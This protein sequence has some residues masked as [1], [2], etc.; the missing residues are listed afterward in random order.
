MESWISFSL[1]AIAAVIHFLFFIFE[2]FV[3]QKP[4]AEKLLK[5]T[6]EQHKAV[7]PWAFNQGFY[8]LMLS[9]GTFLGLYFVLSKKVMMAGLITS[10]TGASM[11]VA[12]IVL[13]FSVP[14]FR[15]SA[16]VQILP[17]ALGF[18]FLIIHILRSMGK[19]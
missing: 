7:K 1:F 18:V 10:F 3:F 16:L 9:L 8:N 13:W 15:K 4:G 2:S 17:P 11:I 14:T 5:L 19:L 6:P 12:G